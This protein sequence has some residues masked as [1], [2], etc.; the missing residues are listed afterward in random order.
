MSETN[1]YL[2]MESSLVNH[3]KP[4]QPNPEFILKLGDRLLGTKDIFV[5][6]RNHAFA[7]MLISFG[8]FVGALIVWVFHKN[9]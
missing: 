3:L 9:K 1:L 8:L 6:D 5:D 4:V 2:S 7:F